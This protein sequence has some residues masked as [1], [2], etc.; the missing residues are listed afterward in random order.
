[1]RTGSTWLVN[2]LKD[3]TYGGY[4]FW[5]NGNDVKP[6]RFE[7]FIKKFDN[8]LVKLHICNPRKIINVVDNLHKRDTNYVISITRDIRDILV[9]ECFYIRYH[10][11]NSRY[12]KLWKNS[13]NEKEYIENYIRSK[14]GRTTMH[15]HT[16][17]TSFTDPN[18]LL[19]HFEDMVKDTKSVVENI[20]E[21]LDIRSEEI[22]KIVER[23]SFKGKTGRDRGQEI[24]HNHNRKGIV[25]DWRNYLNDVTLQ[26]IENL[27][28][29]FLQKINKNKKAKKIA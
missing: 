1:M 9:S 23:Y 3:L 13:Q 25:G 5:E 2:I 22:D 11:R 27:Q 7:A 16:W 19:V 18:Y 15:T 8:K 6:Q 29:K 24:K 4:A 20:C 17:F 28:N 21:F 12:M 10:N 26:Y 14:Y